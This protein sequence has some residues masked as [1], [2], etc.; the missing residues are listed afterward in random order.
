MCCSLLLLC[1]R[2]ACCRAAAASTV[3]WHPSCLPHPPPCLPTLSHTA[4]HCSS[5]SGRGRCW[6]ASIAAASWGRR[7]SCAGAGPGGRT[8]DGGGGGVGCGGDV[9]RDRDAGRCMPSAPPAC[10]SLCTTRHCIASTPPPHIHTAAC[11]PSPTT[12]PTCS[13]IGTLSTGAGAVGSGVGVGVSLFE[14][15][16]SCHPSLPPDPSC[17]LRRRRCCVG[18]C[19]SVIEY[20]HTYF[21][22]GH[23][24]PGHSLAIQGGSQGARLTHSHERQFTYC[25]Q[26]LTLWRE[27]SHEVRCGAAVRL[28]G[29]VATWLGVG[30]ESGGRDAG[31]RFVGGRAATARPVQKPTGCTSPTRPPPPPPPTYPHTH[32]HSHAAPHN[33]LTPPPPAL[34]HLPRCSSSGSLPT[35]TCSARATATR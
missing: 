14:D 11:I 9:D 5:R 6:P 17:M 1:R 28:R 4:P 29:C 34:A 33:T 31:R 30:K 23:V 12:T 13:S 7:R 27:I 26:S 35:P 25:L 19:C 10:L 16:P 22:P 18:C 21:Q 2:V 8:G 15:I 24:E 3:C 20:L 32:T